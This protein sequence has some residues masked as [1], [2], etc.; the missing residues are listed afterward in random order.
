[1]SH[2]SIGQERFGFAGRARSAGASLDEF[3]ELID[4]APVAALLDL[5]YSATAP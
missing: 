2:C 1:M 3:G 5:L 4:W